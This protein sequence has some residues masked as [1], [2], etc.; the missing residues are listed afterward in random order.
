MTLVLN[1]P[2]FVPL[3][4]AAAT[5]HPTGLPAVPVDITHHQL[6]AG[7]VPGRWLATAGPVAI[8]SSPDPQATP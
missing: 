4:R 8:S 3:G 5:R 7:I 2:D 1:A 6:P